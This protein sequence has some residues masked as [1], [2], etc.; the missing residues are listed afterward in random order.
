ME[1]IGRKDF[2]EDFHW[3][4]SVSAYQIEG[5]W[6]SDGKGPSIWDAFVRKPGKVYHRETGDIACDFYHRYLED[7]RLLK[8]LH[9]PCFRFSFS[10]PR[11]IPRGRG[12]TNPK[13]VDFYH[14]VIDACLAMG[15]EPW[16]TLY[17][18]D[19][20]LALEEAYGGWTNRQ[21]LDDFLRYVEFCAQEYGKKVKYWMVMNEPL[22]FTALGYLLGIHA[23]GK[24]GFKNFMPAVHHV[25]LAQAEGIRLLK[26][27][28]PKGVVGTTFSTSPTF[29]YRE[30]NLN[31]LAAAR[32]YDAVLNRLF[33]EPLL[34]RGYPVDALPSLKEVFQRYA[35]KGDEERLIARP[36]F[37]G[38]QNYT[39]EVIKHHGLVPW[40]KGRPIPP[41][42]RKV[43]HQAMGWEVYPESLFLA[44]R[45]FAQ[46]D[47]TLPLIVTENGY[48]AEGETTH[49]PERIA[50]LSQAIKQVHKAQQA[51]VLVKGYFVWTFMD[52]FEWAEGYRPQFGIVYVERRTLERKPKESA[53]WYR[54]FLAGKVTI[55]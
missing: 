8:D 15:I 25:A 31:D 17:H 50:Y 43:P 28:L 19:L 26:Q 45:Q 30:R 48:A 2:G 22:A 35:Q 21:I 46:Y 4:V 3:G 47:P 32:R 40:I 51:G 42:R 29:P 44:L 1:P 36:D 39:R 41:K 14:Q 54:D 52:N 5:G 53:Y 55:E 37:L 16:V 34:G 49:D 23:P 7:I 38:I 12:E 33:V 13:G 27:A 6:N 9:I 11:L 18:W 20:P 24:R 10:W